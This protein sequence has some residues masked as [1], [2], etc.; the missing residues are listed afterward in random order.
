MQWRQLWLEL[1]DK[2]RLVT[3][4]NVFSTSRHGCSLRRMYDACEELRP[5]VF[6]LKTS[7]G[8][9]CGAFINS[10]WYVSDVDCA[11]R[12]LLGRAE[13]GDGYFGNA[14]TYVFSM[15]PFRRYNNDSNNSSVLL[16]VHDRMC[17]GGGGTGPA[18]SI[19]D[20][21]MEK[22]S[23]CRST[24]F[25][26]EPLISSAGESPFNVAAVEVWSFAF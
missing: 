9:V 12:C 7:Q 13:R 10:P 5:L 8:E 22:G 24:T 15:A 20:S 11:L 2:I 16:G 17:I 1:P 25:G 26:N 21:G 6:C 3:P 4:V 23:S 14:G 18:I 19:L